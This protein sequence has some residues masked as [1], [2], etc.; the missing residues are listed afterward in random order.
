MAWRRW[1]V[2]Q[3]GR[4]PAFRTGN[5]GFIQIAGAAGAENGRARDGENEGEAR[6]RRRRLAER[7]SRSP[8][9]L[10]DITLVL[11]GTVAGK[12]QEPGNDPR[13][14]RL[15]PASRSSV[16]AAA[17]GPWLGNPARRTPAH[18]RAV[19]RGP[20]GAS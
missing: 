9:R 4:L 7:G 17:P 10:A 6:L 19:V 18:A 5:D 1:Q 11:P 12:L 15:L 16:H 8:D 20:P 13:R 14:L 2:P 3:Q